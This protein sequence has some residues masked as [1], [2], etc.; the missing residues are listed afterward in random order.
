L[1]RHRSGAG[2]LAADPDLSEKDAR[3]EG[4]GNEGGAGQML[5]AHERLSEAKQAGVTGCAT[6]L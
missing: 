1:L 2:R 6:D 3:Q 5:D 4:C